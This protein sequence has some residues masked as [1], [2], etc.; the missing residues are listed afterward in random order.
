MA[1]APAAIA[2]S[3]NLFPSLDS[4]CMATNTSP[5]FT[6]RE[7]YSNQ[8]TLGLPLWVR[9]SAPRRSWR[10]FI[11]SNYRAPVG[12]GPA[13]YSPA[14]HLAAKA[15]VGPGKK[16]SGGRS[17]RSRPSPAQMHNYARDLRV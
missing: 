11:A 13:G 3:M 15:A 4:P 5:G 14:R 1:T 16:A 17:L 10:K 9:I 2:F 7:S 12:G 6:R 8:L